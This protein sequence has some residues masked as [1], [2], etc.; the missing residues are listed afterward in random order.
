MTLRPAS[1]LGDLGLLGGV[2]LHLV[3][4][5][6]HAA[7]A[8]VDEGDAVEADLGAADVAVVG[9]GVLAVVELDVD[10]RGAFEADLDLDDAVLGGDLQAVHGGVGRDGGLA[11]GGRDVLVAG[12]RALERALLDDEGR[13]DLVP[14]L[15]GLGALEV[16]GEEQFLLLGDRLGRD[17]RKVGRE[18][19]RSDEKQGRETHLVHHVLAPIEDCSSWGRKAGHAALLRQLLERFGVLRI[20]LRVRCT[21]S[22]AVLL[23]SAGA[24]ITERPS[25]VISSSALGIDLQQIENRPVDDQCPTIAVLDQRLDHVR[26]PRAVRPMVYHCNTWRRRW[27]SSSLPR[28]PC[29]VE[30]AD[31]VLGQLLP[32][33]KRVT[34]QEDK[35]GVTATTRILATRLFLDRVSGTRRVG[36][37]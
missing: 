17:R 30:V 20:D 10:H 15:G 23:G 36:L 33:G 29:E 13:D 11:V 9:A 25:V 8:L 35:S 4:V 37:G 7:V 16:V 31:T 6:A 1:E 32:T 21:Y 2:L 18:G 27:A 22:I 14:D 12:L 26:P 24:M 19:G 34:S 3:D 28:A 5:V